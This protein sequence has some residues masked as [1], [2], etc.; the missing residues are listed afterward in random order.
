MALITASFPSVP[1]TIGALHDRGIPLRASCRNC[2]H[3]HDWPVNVLVRRHGRHA[4]W[5]DMKLRC[6]SCDSYGSD[7]QIA[8]LFARFRIAA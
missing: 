2:G 7:L 8:P 1:D 4:R 3:V 6:T 5:W